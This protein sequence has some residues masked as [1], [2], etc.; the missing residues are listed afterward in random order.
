VNDLEAAERQLLETL[1]RGDLSATAELL[2]D[3]FLIT[4]AGWLTEPVGKQAWLDELDGRMTL[5]HF[6]L[7]LIATQRFGDVA[8]VLAESAQEGTHA[9]RPYAMTFRYTDVWVMEDGMWRLA[10]RHASG[11][12]G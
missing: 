9:G 1:Q 2:S 3:V 10:T 11:V 6:D 12:P 7:R 4:T 8:V 5:V